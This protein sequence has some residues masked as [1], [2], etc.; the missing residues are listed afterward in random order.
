MRIVIGGASGFIG[1]PLVQRLRDSG[2]D[3]VRLV[4]R[5]PSGPDEVAWR[6]N[7]GELDPAVLDGVDAVINLAGVGVGDQRWND[8]FKKLLRSSRI[9]ATSTIAK[10]AAAAQS[11]PRVMINASAVGYYSDTGERET[12][13]SG[14]PGDSFLADLCQAWEAATTPAEQAGVRV[15]RIRS[16]LIL[17]PGGGFLKPLMPLF[18]YGLGGKLGSGRQWMPW[19]SLADEL[20]AIEFLLRTDIAGSVNLTGVAP[21]RNAEFTRTLAGVLG[22]PALFTV[23]APVLR[24]ATGEFAHEAVIS[25]RVLPGVLTAS[26]FRYEHQD[27]RSALRWVVGK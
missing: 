17:G 18:K 13:E 16:G 5:E 9:N 23:P 2:H 14:P 27:L 8:E 11:P 26:S 22:R 4:R 15:V 19:I 10:S 7:Q 12:D 20:S 6:P 3:V 21:V 24:V 25:Q 1:K